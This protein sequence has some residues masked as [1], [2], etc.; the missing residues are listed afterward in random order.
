MDEDEYVP[1]ERMP[2]IT[3]A[4]AAADRDPAGAADHVAATDSIRINDAA[5]GKPT[6]VRLRVTDAD[7]N[8][9]ALRTLDGFPLGVGGGGSAI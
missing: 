6:P 5:T 7:G 2:S 8:Y 3:V 1:L 4:L 9:Y